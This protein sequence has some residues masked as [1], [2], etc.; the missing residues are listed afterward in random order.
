M[1]DLTPENQ[2]RLVNDALKDFKIKHAPLEL[3]DTE[4]IVAA[5]KEVNIAVLRL[6][7]SVLDAEAAAKGG[8]QPLDRNAMY[9]LLH[10]LY[11]DN[12]NPWSKDEIL[13][14]NAAW[15]AEQALEVLQ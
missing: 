15:H 8:P 11:L 9:A 3:T 13:Y 2:K 4:A 5:A 14:L 12:F 10:K 6:A 1:S 7:R